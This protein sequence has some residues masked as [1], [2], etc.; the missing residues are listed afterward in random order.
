[1]K[2]TEVKSSN[3]KSLGYDEE[4]HALEVEFQGG[5][6]YTYTA[7]PKEVYERLMEEQAKVESGDTDASVGHVFVELVK[8]AGYDFNHA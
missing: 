3:L 1:M 4:K 5:R 6:L 2:R 8:K 7:V